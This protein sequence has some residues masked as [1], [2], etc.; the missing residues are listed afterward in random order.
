MGT[1]FP[2]QF[3]EAFGSD[4]VTPPQQFT[5]A[6]STP[7]IDYR[8]GSFTGW[9]TMPQVG[10]NGLPDTYNPAAL[11]SY[12][13]SR[14][15][16]IIDAAKQ[17]PLIRI[18]DKNLD[19]MQELIGEISASY[20]ELMSD[21]G[22]C[23]ITIRYDNWMSDWMIHQ[24]LDVEDLHILIDPNPNKPDWRTRWGG[25]IDTIDIKHDD[26]GIHTI[27]LHA[28][29]F[30]EH[31]K[32]MLFGA[33]PIFPPEVQLPRMWIMPGPTRTILSISMF[34]NLA[35]IFFPAL[36]VPTNVFNP[37]AWIN[38][39][40]PD[41]LL[42]FDPLSWPLQVAFVNPI[43]D[44]SRWD[45][46]GATWTTWHEAMRDILNDAGCIF[47]A[48][49][50]LTTDEDSPHTE[51]TDLISG[52]DMIAT[53]F[54]D[55][56]GLGGLTDI[57]NI[58]GQTVQE[59]VRPT[60]NC[61]VFAVEDKSG[62]TGP[63]GTAI[64]GLLNLFGVTLDDLITPVTLEIGQ[65]TE[66]SVIQKVI[67]PANVLNGE[68]IESAAG[69]DS[70]TL[71][72]QLLGVAPAPP[73]VIWWE[74]DYNGMM[75]TD[76]TW[77]K[78]SVKTVMTGGKS[79]SIVNEAQT[80]AIRYGLSQLGQQIDKAIG[81]GG[82][83]QV[84]GPGAGLDN[85]YQGQLDNVLFAWQRFTDPLRALYA[86]DMA[87]NEHFEKGSGTA[88][89]LASVLTLR[90]G[91][92][93]TRTYASFKAT[94]RNGQPW[95]VDVDFTLGD[96]LGFEEEFVIYVDQC[97]GIKRSWDRQQ[98]MNVTLTI[99]D[100]KDKEDPFASAF[101]TLAAVWAGVGNLAGQGWLFG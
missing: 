84:E 89:V 68:P 54:L 70:S 19:V 82:V 76:L 23:S 61:I 99:G 62:Q 33:N 2:F 64:D 53:G 97:T 45:S 83:S 43:T 58:T 90:A 13:N 41:A 5:G 75:T 31:A 10:A 101:R 38:P 40:S 1:Q 24:T 22:I 37:G 4:A 73:K 16:T 6:T 42:N 98:P 93:K 78:G 81:F 7:T 30:R 21:T 27:V 66:G 28:L 55:I 9:I 57:I 92:W 35:R 85:L 20:E 36:S 65:L 18:A 88:Y 91:N 17:R 100:D 80:F 59:L 46:L 67:D 44:Q 26:K 49:T 12:L 47:R 77:H 51:L 14:R 3:G 86:G 95:L 63:T 8:P 32:R 52:V 56:F 69:V 48:Y 39:V 15:Q 50:W 87:W 34:I 79:P 11:Q 29:S 25:K 96:R 60:R 72:Q 74:G 71:V 94:T